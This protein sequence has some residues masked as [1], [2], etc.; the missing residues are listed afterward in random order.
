MILAYGW[1]MFRKRLRGAA[2][3]L[4][5]FAIS[6]GAGA[7]QMNREVLVTWVWTFDHNGLFHI[8]QMAGLVVLIEGIKAGLCAR[9]PSGA[10][11]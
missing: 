10:S 7:V 11:G 4:A 3:M 5:G 2:M 8:L 9:L 6:I 1:L